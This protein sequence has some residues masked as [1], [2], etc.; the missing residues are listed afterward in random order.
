MVCCWTKAIE[1]NQNTVNHSKLSPLATTLAM[2]GQGE[3][4]INVNK[5][6]WHRKDMQVLPSSLLEMWLPYFMWLLSPESNSCHQKLTWSSFLSHFFWF[7]VL[8]I[9]GCPFKLFWGNIYTF[10]M[11]WFS[12]FWRSACSLMSMYICKSASFLLSF[13]FFQ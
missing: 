3:F 9:D 10:Y 13:N 6:T 1:K 2:V 12:P 5:L 8:Y 4:G 11:Y 7:L